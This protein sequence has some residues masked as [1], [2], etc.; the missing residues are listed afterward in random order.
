MSRKCL[1]CSTLCSCGACTTQV[2][3]CGLREHMDGV[4]YRPCWR[5][6]QL[7]AGVCRRDSRHTRVSS[8]D[9]P[10]CSCQATLFA[11][12]V[13]TC[14]DRLLPIGPR[15]KRYSAPFRG[16]WNSTVELPSSIP[17]ACG[18]ACHPNCQPAVCN[19]CRSCT[20]SATWNMSNYALDAYVAQS[21]FGHLRRNS[22]QL[23]PCMFSVKLL[24]GLV[25]ERSVTKSRAVM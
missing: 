17:V 18:S 1:R 2:R 23:L 13:A 10:P 16:R 4:P 8:P 3:T 14:L 25:C 24:A 22:V 9:C 5:L 20:A 15:S 21:F 7:H 11:P 12:A 6:A 19:S